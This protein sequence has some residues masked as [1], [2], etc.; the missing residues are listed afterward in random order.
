MNYGDFNANFVR[1]CD[2]MGRVQ[3]MS[4]GKNNEKHGQW[5]KNRSRRAQDTPTEDRSA[6]KEMPGMAAKQKRKTQVKQWDS[7]GRKG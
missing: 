1:H 5:R 7:P 3:G 6:G 2:L 4:E